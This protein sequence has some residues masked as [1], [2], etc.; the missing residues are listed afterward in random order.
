MDELVGEGSVGVG[1][2][3]G[4]G[5]V[6]DCGVVG[7]DTTSS[8]SSCSPSSSVSSGDSATSSVSFGT[9]F[10]F[11]GSFSF[12]GSFVVAFLTFVT[13][14]VDVVPSFFTFLTSLASLASLGSL[15]SLLVV[16]FFFSAEEGPSLVI[17]AFLV[18][19]GVVGFAGV[20]S[21]VVAAGFFNAGADAGLLEAG[22][23]AGGALGASLVGVFFNAGFTVL[24]SANL[25]KQAT[26]STVAH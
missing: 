16:N 5:T 4:G 26:N 19:V 1:T 8:S 24:I 14:L 10:L 11:V 22:D 15:V 3:M 2:A 21:L 25:S 7:T 13:V 6:E 18:N 20:G 23:A 17:A 9:F 12:V